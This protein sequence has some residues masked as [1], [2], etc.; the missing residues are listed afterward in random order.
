MHAIRLL[1]QVALIVEQEPTSLLPTQVDSIDNCQDLIVSWYTNRCLLRNYFKELDSKPD[2][3]VGK[4]RRK[5]R[6]LI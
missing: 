5:G 2:I 6:E 1:Y 3:N 4:Y